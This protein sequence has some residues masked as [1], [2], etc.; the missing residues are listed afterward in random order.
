MHVPY[1][2][3]TTYLITDEVYTPGLWSRCSSNHQHLQMAGS[4]NALRLLC[5]LN[6]TGIAAVEHVPWLS[7]DR[8]TAAA[9]GSTGFKSHLQCCGHAAPR[10]LGAA[11]GGSQCMA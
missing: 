2:W 8:S 6:V 11:A 3:N 1:I 4:T 5:Q 9:A 10:V 7:A